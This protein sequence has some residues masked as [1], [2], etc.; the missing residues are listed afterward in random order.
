[1]NIFGS[2]GIHFICSYSEWIG[3]IVLVHPFSSSSSFLFGFRDSNLDF[4]QWVCNPNFW[5]WFSLGFGQFR[6]KIRW[7]IRGNSSDKYVEAY[8]TEIGLSEKPEIRKGSSDWSRFDV[9]LLFARFFWGSYSLCCCIFVA[10]RN[11]PFYFVHLIDW[12]NGWWVNWLIDLLIEW[13]SHIGTHSGST[14][15][16]RFFMLLTVC[17]TV[18]AAIHRSLYWLIRLTYARI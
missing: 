9:R 17:S 11:T 10:F 13:C 5:V 8:A 7:Y 15:T 16:F 1:M 18:E 14:E 2:K 3:F 12:L 6:H 4:A